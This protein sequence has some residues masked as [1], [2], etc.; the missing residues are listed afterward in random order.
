MAEYDLQSPYDLAIM[1][2]EFDMISADGWEEYIELA[3]AHSL[4]YKNIN[5]LKAAQRKAGIAKYFNN[6]M[7]RWVLSLVEELDEKMEE[8]E[9]G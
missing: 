9:E 4:G 6:K 8:K 1:H 3:E 2:S 7:I 5:A